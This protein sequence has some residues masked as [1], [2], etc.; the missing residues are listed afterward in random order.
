MNFLKGAA[1]EAY[2]EGIR[3]SMEYWWISDTD[4][5]NKYITTK[6]MMLLIGKLQ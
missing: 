6:H 1:E 2:K 3:A 5:I 4:A